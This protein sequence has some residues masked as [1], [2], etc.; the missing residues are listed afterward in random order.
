[1][2][3]NTG[4]LLVVDDIKWNRDLLCRRLRRQGHHVKVAEDGRQA[5][6][7]L[8]REPFDVV[9]LDIMMPKMNGYQVLEN[10]KEEQH[11]RDIPVIMVSA[12]TEL[13]SMVRCILLGAEDYLFKPFNPV[14]LTARIDAVLEKKRLRDQERAYLQ[15]IANEK[16]RADDLLHVIFP[17]SVVHELKTTNAVKPR[18]HENVAVMLCDIVDFTRYC[19]HHEPEEVIAH[20]QELVEAFEELA[21]HYGVE[22]IKTIG[23]A[24]MGTAG[25]LKPLENPV[26]ACV[27]CGLKMIESAPKM[28]AGWQ[29]RVGIHVGPVVAG[30]V[31]HRQ[32]MFDIWGDTVNM[33]ARVEGTGLPNTVNVSYSAWQHIS[34]YC[35]GESRGSINIRGKGAMEIFRVN[36]LL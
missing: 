14:L 29:V 5:L 23:D 9:L 28:S 7:M 27:R 8:Q 34:D 36:S 24:F 16:K 10:M 18:R 30:V 20:L 15:Q 6:D 12:V 21:L 22:K 32:Y 3:P 13:D 35:R 11:L 2:N 25:L 26:L 17:D 1:M 19:D 4:N 33:A 31:G